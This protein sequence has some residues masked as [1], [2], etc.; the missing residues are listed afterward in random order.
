VY[1]YQ[2]KLTLLIFIIL[3]GIL[4]VSKLNGEASNGIKPSKP[5]KYYISSSRGNDDKNGLSPAKAWK[6]FDRVNS[7]ILS[8]G[9]KIYLKRGDTWNQKLV[10][11]G[12]GND[13]NA[14]LLDAY[15][16]GEKPIIS[17]ND[18]ANDTCV[19]ARNISNWTIRNLDMRNALRGLHLQ[20]DIVKAYNIQVS[21]CNF[22][23]MNYSS[24]DGKI[25]GIGLCIEG[26]GKDTL[27]NPVVKNCKFIRC[28]NGLAINAG[29]QKL[30]CEDCFATGGLS[31]GFS[32]VNVRNSIIRQFVVRDVGG[33]LPYGTCAGFVVWCDGVTIDNCEFTRCKN[34]GGHDGVGFDFEGNSKNIVFTNNVIHDNDGAG[35]MVMSTSGDNSNILIKDCTLYNNCKSPSSDKANYEM[36]CW[37]NGSTGSIINCKIYKSEAANYIHDNFSNFTKTNNKLDSYVNYVQMNM[38][39]P[40]NGKNN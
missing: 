16:N 29:T 11:Q 4:S 18:E 5:S 34:G 32:L 27:Y 24:K 36:L 3:L 23:D 25:V 31:A 33:Y 39:L 14:I 37:N 26:D 9:S 1:R 10:L 38:K 30:L 21:D 40:Q 2:R 19:Y 28:V 6:T 35:I 15:G 13:S 22:Y 17:G 20:Y 8:A 12:S 7:T